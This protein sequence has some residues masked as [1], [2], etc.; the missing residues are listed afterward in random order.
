MCF[1]VI[2]KASATVY[3]PFNFYLPQPPSLNNLTFWLQSLS[4]SPLNIENFQQQVPTDNPSNIN[5][6]MMLMTYDDVQSTPSKTIIE[7]ASTTNSLK[8][9][10]DDQLIDNTLNDSNVDFCRSSQCVISASR[11]EHLID[12]KVDPCENFYNF[13]C[14][15]F[16]RDSTLHDRRDSLNIFTMTDDKLKDQ[17]RRLFTQKVKSNEIEPYKMVKHLFMSCM[18]TDSADARGVEPL[19]KLIKAVGGWPMLVESNWNENDWNF[20]DSVLKLRSYG[21]SRSTSN[22]FR[23]ILQ[24]RNLIKIPTLGFFKTE[25]MDDLKVIPAED[26]SKTEAILKTY[27]SYLVDLAIIIGVKMDKSEIERKIDDAIQFYLELFAL[28]SRYDSNSIENRF[29]FFQSEAYVKYALT[30]WLDL[31]QSLPPLALE[32]SDLKKLNAMEFFTA[33]EKLL[34]RTSKRTL[35][36]YLILRIIGFSARYLTS[37][38][39]KLALHYRME[40]LGV[41]QKEEM[42]KHCVDTVTNSLQLAVESMFSNEY[43]D[44]ESKHTA[45]DIATRLQRFY[46]KK[47]LELSWISAQQRIKILAEINKI[48]ARLRFP[49]ELLSEQQVML[50]YI[51][52]AIDIKKY[53]EAVLSL[54]IFNADRRFLALQAGISLTNTESV[55]VLNYAD[56]K[57]FNKILFPAGV[58]QREIVSPEQPLYLNFANSGFLI[59]YIFTQKFEILQQS[60]LPSNVSSQIDCFIRQYDNYE[61]AEA[62]VKN[63]GRNTLEG[64]IADNGSLKAVY[65][66]YKRWIAENGKEKPLPA[67]NFSNEQFFWISFAQ[68][69]CSVS[70]PEKVKNLNAVNRN[71]FEKFRVIGALSNSYEFA[72]DFKCA[73]NSPMNPTNKCNIF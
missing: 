31:F 12:W 58:L 49:S 53:M 4:T 9:D 44:L 19:R 34:S 51:N 45:I 14:G 22:V 35:A 48:I 46:E 71:S 38:M 17:L 59:G 40:L 72:K 67:L 52:V 32:R 66:S 3:Q 13:A 24:L 42:W 57:D 8:H 28:N 55:G 47:L 10:D 50:F 64:N 6:Q 61:D 43:F 15:K 1:L 69:F 56:A 33:Y 73:K 16:I 63:N 68:L 26:S 62:G 18:D 23:G 2:F 20:E 39:K 21:G 60:H 5:Y 41:K 11:M 30:Q 27:K 7:T 37:E 65:A 70:R 36:N 25:I 29:S 54:T